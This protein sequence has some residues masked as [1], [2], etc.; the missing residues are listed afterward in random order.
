MVLIDMKMPE[1][2]A[3]CPLKSVEGIFKTKYKTNYLCK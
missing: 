1:C 2:C 3:N